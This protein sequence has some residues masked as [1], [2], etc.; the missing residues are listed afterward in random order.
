MGTSTRGHAGGSTT[1]GRLVVG[2]DGTTKGWVA[3]ILADGRFCSAKTFA[4]AGDAI[5]A[6]PEAQF[7]GIDI[8]IGFPPDAPKRK[9]DTLARELLKERRDCCFFAPPLSILRASSAKKQ[10]AEKRRLGAKPS[11]F[12]W[13]LK[14]KI[15]E[16]DDLVVEHGV[17][18]REVHPEVS[19][20]EMNNG[21]PVRHKKKSWTG[22]MIRR[23]LLK[24][25]GIELPDQIELDQHAGPDDILD[26]AAAAWTAWRCASRATG[27]YSVP[28]K[29]E[30]ELDRGRPVAIWV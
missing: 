27:L 17:R 22:I 8:P 10:G 24:E 5:A 16:V 13:G 20:R 4:K 25:Q 1:A 7:F 12:A 9:A 3:I 11:P 29:R 26:A 6:Y 18:L 19:F 30:A 23:R 15:L 14:K 28:A 2:L 21:Q